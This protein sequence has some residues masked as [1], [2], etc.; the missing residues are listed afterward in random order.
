MAFTSTVIILG[1]KWEGGREGAEGVP[2]FGGLQGTGA[3]A[4]GGLGVGQTGGGAMAPGGGHRQEMTH[5]GTIP[6][7]LFMTP[8]TRDGGRV[9]GVDQQDGRPKV[10]STQTDQQSKTA[11]TFS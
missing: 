1:I 2:G 9:T 7:S 5:S 10:L 8:D 4:P 3:T 6:L 11:K